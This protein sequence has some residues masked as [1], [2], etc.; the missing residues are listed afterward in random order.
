MKN[1]TKATKALDAY[2]A[3]YNNLQIIEGLCNRVD[4]QGKIV[5]LSGVE[6]DSQIADVLMD[7][8]AVLTANS[9][10]GAG[11]YTAATAKYVVNADS[12]ISNTTTNAV[13]IASLDFSK[14]LASGAVKWADISS[15]DGTFLTDLNDLKVALGQF[16]DSVSSFVL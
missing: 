15:N 4:A 6:A 13:E 7:I 10:S 2:A 16:R 11:T 1:Q 3:I 9:N 8:N 12:Y 5:E 14:F